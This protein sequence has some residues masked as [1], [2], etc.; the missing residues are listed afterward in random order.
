MSTGQKA[1]EQ[2]KWGEP[3]PREIRERVVKVA[4]LSTP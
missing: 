2:L 4:S 1:V 3:P